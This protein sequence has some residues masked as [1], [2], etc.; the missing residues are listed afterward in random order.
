[1]S[2]KSGTEKAGFIEKAVGN[3]IDKVADSAVDK[4]KDKIDAVAPSF[5]GDAVEGA[6]DNLKDNA[7]DKAK[8]EIKDIAVRQ[9]KKIV[10]KVIRRSVTLALIT[11]CVV[12][13]VKNKDAVIGFVKS[14][15]G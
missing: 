13:A 11:G 2:K 12:I 7:L 6:L 8:T 3:A 15:I 5:I 14:K 9:S 10:K 4:V 1:M